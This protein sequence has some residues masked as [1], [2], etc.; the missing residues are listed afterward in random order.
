LAG[1]YAYRVEGQKTAAFEML[2]Q[3]FLQPPDWVIVPIGCGTNIAA[4]AKGFQEYYQ[5]GL[6]DAIP[7]LMGVQAQGAS[8][9][10]NSYLQGHKKITPLSG[11]DTIASAIAVPNPID[12]IKALNTIYTTRVAQSL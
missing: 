5:L 7:K 11:A 10:V 12:G 8:A 9:V 1:D 2:D 3:F 4:Y 6:I